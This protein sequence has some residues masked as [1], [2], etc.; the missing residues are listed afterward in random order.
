[1]AGQG[2]GRDTSI[3]VVDR[4]TGEVIASGDTNY[5]G[6]GLYAF[7]AYN[8]YGFVESTPLSNPCVSGTVNGIALGGSTPAFMEYRVTLD[9]NAFKIERGPTLATITQ[10]ATRTLGRTIVGNQYYLEIGTASPGFSPGTFDWVRVT[11]Y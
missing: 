4:A 1:M 2:A 8:S 3:N 10:S 6:W 7:A 5:C 11:T 9:G